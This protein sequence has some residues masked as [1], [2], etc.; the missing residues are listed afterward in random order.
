MSVNPHAQLRLVC[1]DLDGTLIEADSQKPVGKEFFRKLEKGREKGPLVWVIN[2]GRSWSDLQE[3]LELRRF[4]IWPDWAVTLER[5]I[6]LLRDKSAI[7]WYEWNRKGELLHEQLFATV[8][9]VWGRI[10]VWLARETKAQV[11]ADAGSPVG[12]VATDVE[13][14]DRISAFIEPILREWP[15]LVAVRNTVYFRFSHAF[16]NKGTCLQ[17]ISHGLGVH[18]FEIL[19][20]GDQHHDA[21]MMRRRLADHLVC[22]S[23]ADEAI[24]RQVAA[25]GGYVASQ[26]C[27][28]GVMEGWNALIHQEDLAS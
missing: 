4:P 3:T 19:V 10:E 12:I 11:V 18:P 15:N 7:G 5:E 1:T 22:P 20:A 8:K 26:T 21:P 2:S 23:N 13:E 9:P 16:Y 17:A 24:K 27:M 14:A 25:E 28:A 6:W